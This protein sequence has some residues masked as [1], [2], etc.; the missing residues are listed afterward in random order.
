MPL[1]FR[2]GLLAALLLCGLPLCADSPRV[3][4]Q[5]RKQFSSNHRFFLISKLKESRTQVFRT[6][7]P[8]SIL[9]EV[10]IYMSVSELSNDG[11]H[12]ADIYEGGNI[13][14]DDIRPSDPLITFYNASGTRRIVTLGEIVP[15]RKALR[16]ATSG[17]VWED[18]LGFQ[19]TGQFMI[20]LNDGKTLVLNPE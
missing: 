20:V 8:A 4:R 14:G 11:R 12:I 5:D 15:E 16:R 3:A 1:L 2:H 19:S 7:R 17:N 6:D 9:W 10:P 18:F 13:L